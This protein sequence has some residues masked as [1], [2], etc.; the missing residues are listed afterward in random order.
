MILLLPLGKGRCARRSGVR[1]VL[2]GSLTFTKRFA[3]LQIDIGTTHFIKIGLP[4]RWQ[5]HV[6]G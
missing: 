1:S 4:E 3:T 2:A 5:S 6:S